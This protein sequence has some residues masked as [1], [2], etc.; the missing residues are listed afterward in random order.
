[1]SKMKISNKMIPLVASAAIAT[2]FL[3]SSNSVKADKVDD[4]KIDREKSQ[5][6]LVKN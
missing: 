1:M 5:N 4:Q 2:L 3:N 6:D